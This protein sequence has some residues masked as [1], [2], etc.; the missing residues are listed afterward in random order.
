MF[1]GLVFWSAGFLFTWVFDGLFQMVRYPVG[2]YPGWMRLVLTWVVPVGVMTTVP[3]EALSGDLP[4]K[5]FVGSV[6]LAI[7]LVIGA[8]VVFQSGLRRY[9]SASS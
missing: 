5:T 4:M 6:I 2:L 3:A 1:A 8:S 9:A 7:V